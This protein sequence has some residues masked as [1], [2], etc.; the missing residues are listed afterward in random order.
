MKQKL[1]SLFA[2]TLFV[3]NFLN[4]QIDGH[5]CGF[6]EH[7]ENIQ[8]NHEGEWAK[9]KSQEDQLNGFIEKFV[10]EKQRLRAEGKLPQKKSSAPKYT[11]PV[12]VHVLHDGGPENISDEQIYSAIDRLNECFQGLN[13]ELASVQPE[14]TALTTTLDIEFKLATKA[15]DGSCFKGITRTKSSQTNSGDEAAQLNAI[16]SG[17]DVYNGNWPQNEYLNIFTVNTL[18]SA[19]AAAYAYFPSNTGM[20]RGVWTQHIYFGSIGTSTQGRSGTV[21][22]E[23]GHWFALYH[24]WGN[25]NLVSQD[26]VPSDC[27]VEDDLV[28]DTPE[29]IGNKSCDVNANTCDA[30]NAYWGYDIRDNV[31]NFMEY[32]Y[33]FKMF[34]IGQ[35]DRMEAALNSSTGG[36]NN[37]WSPSNLTK[38][39]VDAPAALCKADFSAERTTI[40]AGETIQFTDYSYS[41]VVGW[42]WDFDGATVV[43]SVNDQNPSVTFNNPG[44]YTISLEVT[45]GSSTVSDSKI[46]YIK[47]LANPGVSSPLKESFENTSTLPDDN[48]EI[49]EEYAKDF[50]ILDEASVTGNYS[51]RITN[52]SSRAGNVYELTSTTVDLSA[53]IQPMISFKY[54]WAKR[55][56]SNKD[57]LQVFASYDCGETFTQVEY[58]ATSKLETG[59]ITTSKYVPTEDEWEVRI[60]DDLAPEYAVSNFMCK[61]VFTSDGGNHLYIEDINIRDASN[62]VTVNDGIEEVNSVLLSPN[63]TQGDL[64]MTIN[65]NQSSNV[66]IKVYDMLGKVVEYRD[67]GMFN[68][69]ASKQYFDLNH[70]DAGTY[71]FNVLLNEIP[72][73]AER[74]IIE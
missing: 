50:D 57:K 29:T 63:P 35:G 47:V 43:G 59:E 54:A 56:S 66:T 32:S 26:P 69:G 38:T 45:D 41:N 40:C 39:G 46:D 22:H 12:V 9:M 18:G 7:R 49:T 16:I 73:S 6:D 31:E 67:L 21:V 28:D 62:L 72:V 58:I 3:T 19:G 4:A 10:A 74:I 52:S 30:D 42:T 53:A 13:P 11:I 55:E 64:N 68:I 23:L 1:L 20:N 14:F 61:F 65:L 48:W 70:L 36:R 60:I 27:G 17:N 51:L 2:F 5:H 34:T 25:K 24:P 8:L 15:P 37:L 33:C 71:F 44:V